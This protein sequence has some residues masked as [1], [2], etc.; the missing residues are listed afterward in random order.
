[1]INNNNKKKITIGITASSTT[2]TLALEGCSK[3]PLFELL[4]VTELD[5]YKKCVYE[6]SVSSNRHLRVANRIHVTVVPLFSQPL[7]T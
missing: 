5:R 3:P 4:H 7:S 6:Y 2:T 1:M